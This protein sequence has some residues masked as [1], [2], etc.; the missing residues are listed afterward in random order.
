MPSPERIRRSD[1]LL[2]GGEKLEGDWVVWSPFS[3]FW[4]VR[5]AILPTILGREG[6]PM[7]GLEIPFARIHGNPLAGLAV[8]RVP[9][10]HRPV[11]IRSLPHFLR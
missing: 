4:Q 2:K 10:V 5:H 6:E 11:R 9:V 7:A 3:F 8:V 1:S